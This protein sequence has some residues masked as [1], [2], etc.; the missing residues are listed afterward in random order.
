VLSKTH[1]GLKI[2]SYG[3]RGSIQAMAR[4]VSEITMQNTVNNAE[5]VLKQS[6]GNYLFV[7]K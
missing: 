7:T 4:G 2:T 3:K 5:V 6:S 1:P